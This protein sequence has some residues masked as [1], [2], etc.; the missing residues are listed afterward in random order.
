[1]MRQLESA[2]GP[3][4]VMLALLFLVSPSYGQS[5]K[6]IDVWVGTAKQEGVFHCRLNLNTGKLSAPVPMKT[7]GGAGFLALAPDGKTL[8]A[9]AKDQQESGIASYRIQSRG[10]SVALERTGWVSTGDG[11][12]ACVAVDRSGRVVSSAQYGGGSVTTYLANPK[13]GKILERVELIEQGPGSGVNAKRQRTAH[14]HWVGTSP[15]NKLLL[16][17]DLGMDAVVVYQLDSSNGR[18][19][20]FSKIAC[21]PGGGPRHMKFHPNGKYAYVLNELTLTISVFAFNPDTGAFDSIEEVK[22]L[23]DRLKDR[24]LNSAAEIRVHPSGKF[25][26][27]SNR[28]HDS[29]TVFAVDQATGKL[30]FVE[31]EHVRGSWPRNFNLDP[32]GQW[33]IAAGQYSNT[34][35]VF[36][37]DQETGELVYSRTIVNIPDPIC[38]EFGKR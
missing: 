36:E 17:P 33:L 5:D 9:T 6:W 20:S 32:T 4:L 37:I 23:P 3:F 7:L 22:T 12:A 2:R 27:S 21:P 35:A 10:Q 11:G 30:T 24:H 38:V 16:V 15:D 26:Y 25:V 28:G 31:H 34:V 19:N 13:T 18:L 14:P 1:M 29:I 8:Y